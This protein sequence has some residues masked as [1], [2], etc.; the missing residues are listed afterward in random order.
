MPRWFVTKVS[1]KDEGNE[2]HSGYAIGSRY[3]RFHLGL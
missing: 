3:S 2:G 1:M